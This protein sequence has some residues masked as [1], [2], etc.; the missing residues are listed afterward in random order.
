MSFLTEYC[1]SKPILSQIVR[2]QAR[3]FPTNHMATDP[4]QNPTSVKTIV[5]M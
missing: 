1:L 3:L 5:D 2:S 4:E